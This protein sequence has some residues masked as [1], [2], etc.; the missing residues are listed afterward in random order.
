MC[1]GGSCTSGVV[2]VSMQCSRVAV[3][4]EDL[5]H[6]DE[7]RFIKGQ[8]VTHYFYQYIISVN[9]VCLL[10]IFVF[11]LCPAHKASLFCFHW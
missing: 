2:K 11:F 1:G 3:R 7:T 4:R 10:T 9:Y 6:F 8:L 5:V